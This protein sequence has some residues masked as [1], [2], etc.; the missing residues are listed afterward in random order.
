[1]ANILNTIRSQNSSHVI[2]QKADHQAGMT[3]QELADFVQQTG[4]QLQAFGLR[5]NHKIALALSE[6]EPST[7]TAL[8]GSMQSSIA[9]PLRRFEN[10]EM[11]EMSLDTTSPDALILDTRVPN[12]KN[13]YKLAQQKNI[14]IITLHTGEMD[15]GKF[16]LDSDADFSHLDKSGSVAEPEQDDIAVIFQTSGT[17]GTPKLVAHTQGHFLHN[18]SVHRN[19]LG[20]NEEIHCLNVLSQRAQWGITTA[21]T[22]LLSGGKLSLYPHSDL[23]FQNIGESKLPL[24]IAETQAN[25]LPLTPDTLCDMK[26]LLEK[27]GRVA[28]T[29]QNSSLRVIETSSSPALPTLLEQTRNLLPNMSVLETFGATEAG[30]IAANTAKKYKDGTVGRIIEGVEIRVVDINEAAVKQGEIGELWVRSPSVARYYN[31]PE[32]N[33]R[34]FSP[35][36]FYKTGDIVQIDEEGFLTVLGRKAELIHTHGQE[37]LPSVIDRNLMQIKGIDKAIS[38]PVITDHGTELGVIITPRAANNTNMLEAVREGVGFQPHCVFMDAV[39]KQFL[40]PKG[41]PR[42]NIIATGLANFPQLE[43]GQEI[44]A[45]SGCFPGHGRG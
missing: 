20:I 22:T 24:L 41:T 18:A 19:T 15:S 9:V 4:N 30:P 39:P 26:Q 29:L 31:N 16:T 2:L 1:M 45:R 23:H 10:D 27:R 32:A 5:R 42:R 34:S 35:D 40:T 25:W 7:I 37:I 6:G 17:T 43:N 21:M 11:A 33:S 14:P 8:L 44:G 38:F 36:G 28:E 12:W 3:M 13:I